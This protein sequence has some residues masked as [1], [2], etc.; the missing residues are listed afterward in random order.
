MILGL[1]GLGNFYS[2]DTNLHLIACDVGQG[3]AILAIY[4][5][6]QVLID[7]GPGEEILDCIGKH[8]P[9]WD[10]E[11][12][13][14]VLTHPQVDHY[15]GLIEV[16]KRYKVDTF[17]ANGLDSSASSYQVLKN[18]VGGNGSRVLSPIE[19]MALRVGMIYL[20]ILAPN[21]SLLE[22][23]APNSPTNILG[24]FTSKRD[25]N[26]FSVVAILR[27][28]QF[29]ALLTGDISPQEIPEILAGG[30]MRDVEYIKVPHHGSKNGLTLDLLEASTPEMAVISVGKNN[31]GQPSEEII[32]MLKDKGIKVSRTDELG[33]I[34]VVNDGSSFWT[35]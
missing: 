20:D 25:P 5:N 33:D 3:D 18:A 34:E 15:G 2:P 14:V 31:Y 7:G 30:R 13:L 26:D 4:K 27:L 28:G 9:F 1:I 8:V 19:G 23:E 12:E 10:R 17:L 21:Q 29:D 6:T 11:I 24:A 22:A 32:R 35:E 16:F